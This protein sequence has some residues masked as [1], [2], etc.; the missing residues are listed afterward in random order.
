MVKVTTCRNRESAV[1]VNIVPASLVE[2][3][4]EPGVLPEALNAKPNG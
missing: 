2:D 3:M 4:A 1:G